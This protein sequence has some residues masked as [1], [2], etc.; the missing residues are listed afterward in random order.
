MEET[1][2]IRG[3]VKELVVEEK[4]PTQ[5]SSQPQLIRPNC[6]RL[7]SSASNP[8]TFTDDVVALEAKVVD[9]EHQIGLLTAANVQMEDELY[10]LKAKV[11]SYGEELLR[12]KHSSIRIPTSR[13]RTVSSLKSRNPRTAPQG[14]Q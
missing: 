11:D 4:E 9:K 2:E 13:C 7:C 12:S 3:P 6:K 14:T 8:S 1:K 5:K 10:Q